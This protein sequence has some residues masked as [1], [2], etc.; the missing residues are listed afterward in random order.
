L[1]ARVTL[2]MELA[3]DT[4]SAMVKGQYHDELETVANYLRVN[5]ELTATLEGHTDNTSPATAQQVSKA[6]AQSVAD[7]LVTKFGIERSR[8]SVEGFGSTRRDTYNI[9]AAQRQE[10]RRVSII[11]GYPD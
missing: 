9:N 6:R 1:P 7:Y 3:F 11:I 2:A 5:P 4:D 10:N 8:L